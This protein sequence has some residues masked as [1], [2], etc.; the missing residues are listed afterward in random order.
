MVQELVKKWEDDH[1]QRVKKVEDAKIKIRILENVGSS[2]LILASTIALIGNGIGIIGFIFNFI[3]G[4]GEGSMYL[5]LA[6][7]AVVSVGGIIT[8]ISYIIIFSI[9]VTAKVY[10]FGIKDTLKEEKRSF[11]KFK[12]E[13]SEKGIN[14]SN[15]IEHPTFYICSI[16]DAF[17]GLINSK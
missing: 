12:L 11:E 9:L 13:I 3:P 8:T 16:G 17:S 2:F 10:L 5:V 6:G 4:Q 7:G 1:D 14:L 15:K